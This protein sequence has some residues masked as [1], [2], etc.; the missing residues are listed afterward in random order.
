MHSSLLSHDNIIINSLIHIRNKYDYLA[1][2]MWLYAEVSSFVRPLKSWMK[3]MLAL[4]AFS[5]YI[6]IHCL[7]LIKWKVKL[8]VLHYG[9]FDILCSGCIRHILASIF[10]NHNTVYDICARYLNIFNYLLLFELHLHFFNYTV[11]SKSAVT[12]NTVSHN[13]TFSNDWMNQSIYTI[14]NIFKLNSFFFFFREYLDF[15]SNINHAE[16]MWQV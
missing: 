16:V 10:I 13:A 1:F 12:K 9:I 2:L 14:L 6:T 3:Q 11:L 15:D 4:T 5:S 7:F 8:R